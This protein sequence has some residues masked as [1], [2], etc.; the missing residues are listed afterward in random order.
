MIK[1]LI[2]FIILLYIIFYIRDTFTVDLNNKYNINNFKMITLNNNDDKYLE[3]FKNIYYILKNND[4]KNMDIETSIKISKNNINT[5][6]Y[7]IFIPNEQIRNSKKIMNELINQLGFPNDKYLNK[8]FEKYLLYD[9]QVIVGHDY[10]RNYNRI[11]FN[12]KFNNLYY[13]FGIDYNNKG[14]IISKKR[15]SEI[16]NKFD[17]RTNLEKTFPKKIINNFLNEFNISVFDSVYQKVNTSINGNKP[18][19]YYFSFIVP[20]T[21]ELVIDKMDNI[22]NDIFMDYKNNNKFINWYNFNKNNLVNWITFGIDNNYDIDINL[23]VVDN[24]F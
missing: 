21:L 2:L 18:T 20:L 1:Y 8:L 14:K 6:R 23:Y 5:E 13:M 9:G 17:I 11:Y 3:L 22:L 12:Y 16:I 7:Y 19:T 24:K 15:Y 10:G 4:I